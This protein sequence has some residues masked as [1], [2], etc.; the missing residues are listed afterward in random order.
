MVASNEPWQLVTTF[1]EWGKAPRSTG[2]P[3]ASASGYGQYL[4]ALHANGNGTPP[5]QPTATPQLPTH[6]L[7]PQPVIRPALRRPPTR[8]PLRYPN[9]GSHR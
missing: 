7:L 6:R 5:P 3:T 4:D 9:Q 2:R 8:R 1:N